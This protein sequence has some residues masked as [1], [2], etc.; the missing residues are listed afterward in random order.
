MGIHVLGRSSLL[1]CLGAAAAAAPAP[2]EVTHALQDLRALH[3]AEWS[4]QS[5]QRTR[6]PDADIPQTLKG[7]IT[8]AF[9]RLE[10]GFERVSRKTSDFSGACTTLVLCTRGVVA[11]G[12]RDP[13]HTKLLSCR[14]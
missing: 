13:T 8:E 4:G 2:Y 7:A 3:D 12:I 10:S 6:A 9:H 11:V 5:Q 14:T 1:A